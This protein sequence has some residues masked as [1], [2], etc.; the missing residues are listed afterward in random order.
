MAG[1]NHQNEVDTASERRA[2]RFA[3]ATTE[4]ERLEMELLLLAIYR[5]HG[6]DFRSYAPASLHRRIRKH[7]DSAHVATISGLTEL[8]LHEPTALQRLLHDLSVNVTAMFRDPTFFAEFRK[9]V[10]PLLRTYPTVR[11]WHAGCSTGEEVYAMSILL[12]EEGLYD[13]CRIYATDMDSTVLDHA[14]QG[15]FPLSRMKEYTSNY[16]LGGGKRSLSDYF[17][18]KYD[19]A[20]F[21]PRLAKNVLFTQHNL[22]MDRGFSEFNVILCRNVL[23]YFD[24]TLK[25]HALNLFSES[26]ATLGILCLG[27]KESLRFTDF[28]DEFSALSA[29]ERIYRRNK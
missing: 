28:E 2:E 23:I 29:R 22:A 16:F 17:I 26:L 18:A 4:L 1:P 5:H 13:R 15:I 9:S 14:R 11:I 25:N 6:F 24:R 20:L 3:I 27:R 19:G 12:E 10:V 8:I 7:M 21:A